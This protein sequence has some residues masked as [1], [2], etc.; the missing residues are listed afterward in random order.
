MHSFSSFW[1]IQ[2]WY[3]LWK[4][5]CEH[6]IMKATVDDKLSIQVNEVVHKALQGSIAG[7]IASGVIL[8]KSLTAHSFSSANAGAIAGLAAKNTGAKT[9]VAM[10]DPTDVVVPFFQQGIR[11]ELSGTAVGL[12]AG[13][14]VTI[15][16]EGTLLT[17]T[18]Y[19]LHR[20][21][22]FKQ[23][24]EE[25]FKRGLVQELFTSANTVIG[26]TV[27]TALGQAVIPVPIVGATVGGAVGG[28]V[29]QLCGKLEGWVI[30][31]VIRN[32]RAVTLPQLR[33]TSFFDDPTFMDQKQ[34]SEQ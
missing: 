32:P 9:V 31:K 21:E 20:K 4:N 27:G 19:K 12:I 7:V 25:E 22:K 3:S 5:N 1:S 10:Y 33:K 15:A 29:G 16:V 11:S 23:I 2:V 13:F 8:R 14:T 26:V 6:L 34:T 24:S 30:A 28:A 18:I 17:R